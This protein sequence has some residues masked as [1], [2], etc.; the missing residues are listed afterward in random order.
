VLETNKWDFV[1]VDDLL[2]P[3][4]LKSKVR[5]NRL[6]MAGYLGFEV[7]QA[8]TITRA[9]HGCRDYRLSAEGLCFRTQVAVR[10]LT[11]NVKEWTKFRE[12][13][14]LSDDTSRQD[15]YEADAFIVENILGVYLWEAE[16]AVKAL[17]GLDS[18]GVHSQIDTLT[19][20]WKQI[21]SMVQPAIES[22]V[23]L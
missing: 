9:K 5:R 6:E 12:G 17:K 19:K 8:K 22:S 2:L 15:E 3:N 14:C 4:V 18:S 7:L 21:R 1:L 10:T 13:Q 11:L 23:S 16:E 20:R